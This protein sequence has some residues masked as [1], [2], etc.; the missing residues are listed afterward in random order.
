MK[1]DIGGRCV[2]TIFKGEYYNNTSCGST[3]LAAAIVRCDIMW[4]ALKWVVGWWQV[5]L[6][7]A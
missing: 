6:L 2:N 1:N 4:M 3:N 5:A 7:P